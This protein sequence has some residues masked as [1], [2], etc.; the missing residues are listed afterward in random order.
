[1]ELFDKAKGTVLVSVGF[2]VQGVVSLVTAVP[3][4]LALFVAGLPNRPDAHSLQSLGLS[5]RGVETGVADGER[6]MF[7]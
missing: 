7:F 6:L 4:A 1:M 5:R 2:M 3:L